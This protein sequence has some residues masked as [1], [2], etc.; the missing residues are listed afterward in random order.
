[1]SQSK[2][3]FNDMLSKGFDSA[4][5]ESMLWQRFEENPEEWSWVPEVYRRHGHAWDFEDYS[6]KRDD[7]GQ[8]TTFTAS[9]I[10]RLVKVADNL[11]NKKQHKIADLIDSLFRYI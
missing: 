4:K 6:K 8:Y 1:M 11:D 2:Y 9:T 10:N 5:Q 3:S 7:K